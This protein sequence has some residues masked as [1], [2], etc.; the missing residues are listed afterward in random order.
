MSWVFTMANDELMGWKGDLFQLQWA[1][2]MPPITLATLM[3][4]KNE[5]TVSVPWALCTLSSSL[6][7]STST[8][9][10]TCTTTTTSSSSTASSSP[11]APQRVAKLPA[12]FGLFGRHK[13]LHC[14][15]WCQPFQLSSSWYSRNVHMSQNVGLCEVARCCWICCWKIVNVFWN[16]RF[17]AIFQWFGWSEWVLTLPIPMWA[18]RASAIISTESEIRLGSFYVARF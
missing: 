11:L 9:N 1:Y 2:L 13:W 18:Q 16:I 5:A 6:Y 3:L 12:T 10:T 15:W 14:R 17:I 8:T 4:Q 7:T